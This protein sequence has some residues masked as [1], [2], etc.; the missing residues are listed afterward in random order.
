MLPLGVQP[1][2]VAAKLYAGLHLADDAGA[3]RIVIAGLP[4]GADWAAVA[5]RLRRAAV[6]KP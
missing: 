3:Q 1:K 6:T 5:D 2:E 4:N